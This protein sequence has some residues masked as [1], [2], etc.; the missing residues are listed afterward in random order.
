LGDQLP[1]Q[2]AFLYQ[3]QAAQVRVGV[4]QP[5]PPDQALDL[6]VGEGAVRLVHDQA[7]PVFEA[8]P[9]H[10]VLVLAFEGTEQGVG[11]HL[12]ELALGLDVDPVH[13]APPA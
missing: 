7:D 3:V 9:E 8:Q 5:G 4:A 10:E 13:R 1:V 12:P 6:G 2:P 11:A